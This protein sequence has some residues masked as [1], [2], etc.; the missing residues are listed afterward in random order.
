[1]QRGGQEVIMW[2]GGMRDGHLV[3]MIIEN[4]Y[5]PK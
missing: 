1:M 2:Q 5:V 4:L 3:R